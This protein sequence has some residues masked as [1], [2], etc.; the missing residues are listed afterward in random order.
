MRAW[1]LL[2]QGFIV[3]TI[4]FFGLYIAASLFPG[5]ALAEW[6]TIALTLFAFGL[7][8]FLAFKG[9]RRARLNSRGTLAEWLDGVALLGVALA[10][11]AVLYQGLSVIAA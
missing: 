4:H 3:W 5:T 1:L 11:V 6:L 10:A 7:L 8:L 2:L 9:L